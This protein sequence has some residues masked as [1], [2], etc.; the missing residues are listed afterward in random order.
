MHH[1]GSLC[2][3]WVSLCY[4]YHR[5]PEELCWWLHHPIHVHSHI[6]LSTS[7]IAYVIVTSFVT[8][9]SLQLKHATWLEPLRLSW[10]LLWLLKSF[11]YWLWPFVNFD[12][13]IELD[14]K[15]KLFGQCLF[16]SIF[17]VNFNFGL[18]FFDWSLEIAHLANLS[19]WFF[20]RIFSNLS[21][22]KSLSTFNVEF[23]MGVL[24]IN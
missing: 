12:F 10:P 7:T 3:T 13:C 20:Q 4:T 23:K 9:T 5:M 22:L 16:C 14:Q 1:L 18:Y 11:N 24:E 15:S 17:H 6:S 21:N 19:L 2:A 8:L